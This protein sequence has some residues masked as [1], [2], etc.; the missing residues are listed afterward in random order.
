M[1]NK[2]DSA[3]NNLVSWLAEQ[4]FPINPAV[5]VNG[6]SFPNVVLV[7]DF[8]SPLEPVRLTSEQGNDLS[9]LIK[10]SVTAITGKRNVRINFDNNNG[11]FWASV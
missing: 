6:S 2:N 11:V 5:K 4:K 10:E 1:R 9:H 8:G 7:V 3:T